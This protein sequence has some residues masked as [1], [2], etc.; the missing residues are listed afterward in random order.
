MATKNRPGHSEKKA[1]AKSLKEKRREKR[2]K[3]AAHQIEG[4]RPVEKTLAHAR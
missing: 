4:N 3:H 1:A 2:A